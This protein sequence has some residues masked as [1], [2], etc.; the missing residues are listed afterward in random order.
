MGEEWL[1]DVLFYVLV[2]ENI[3]YV[4]DLVQGGGVM[5]RHGCYGSLEP[6]SR[7]GAG[8]VSGQ[9]GTLWAA[10]AQDPSCR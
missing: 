8:S 6:R 9:R 7:G 2:T 10:R 5:V 4:S 1:S 3:T